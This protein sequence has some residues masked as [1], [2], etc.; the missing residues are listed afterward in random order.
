MRKPLESL[1]PYYRNL[2]IISF[3]NSKDRVLDCTVRSSQASLIVNVEGR[4]LVYFSF[5]L[6]KQPLKGAFPFSF[7]VLEIPQSCDVVQGVFHVDTF[8][9]KPESEEQIMLL[10]SNLVLSADGD[11]SQIAIIDLKKLNEECGRQASVI[12]DSTGTFRFSE[13]A[14]ETITKAIAG[15][16]LLLNGVLTTVP[17]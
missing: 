12:V 8:Q 10:L 14:R 15:K 11:E 13:W 9:N 3:D 1:S 5:E 2:G 16:E 7:W 4:F 17:I 6:F